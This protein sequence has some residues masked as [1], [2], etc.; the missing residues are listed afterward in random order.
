MKEARLYELAYEALLERWGRSYD[1]VRNYP[2]CD[3]FE[4]SKRNYGMSY[5]ILK[6]K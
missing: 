2:N 3:F 6:M 1:D 5:L 4:K